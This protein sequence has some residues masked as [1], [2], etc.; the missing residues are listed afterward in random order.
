MS[1]THEELEEMLPA[2]AL[3]ILEP[4]ELEQ[5]L[6]Y[7]RDHPECA[8]LLQ[9]YRDAAARLSL[10]LPRRR[11]DPVRAGALRSSLMARAAGRTGGRVDGRTEGPALGLRIGQWMGWAVAAG[12]ASILLVHHS[13]HRS[14]DYGWLAAGILVV[15]LMGL[16]IYA[17]G[18]RRRV[19]ELEKKTRR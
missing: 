15:V 5:V 7:A 11:L 16:A 9:E 10:G 12:L 1:L 14:L 19:V 18:Q 4:T 6:A 3:D 2:A 17:R 13:V 8:K